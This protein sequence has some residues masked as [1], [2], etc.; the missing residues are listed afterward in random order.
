MP[1]TTDLSNLLIYSNTY[2]AN[3]HA[4]NDARKAIVEGLYKLP[5]L[6]HQYIRIDKHLLGNR[7]ICRNRFYGYHITN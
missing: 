3:V 2:N 1:D 4:G 7:E 6:N 5:Y